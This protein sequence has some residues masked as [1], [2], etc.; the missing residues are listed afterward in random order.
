M[1]KL[2]EHLFIADNGDLFDTRKADWHKHPLREKY[3]YH[4]SDIDSLSKVKACLRAGKYAWPGGYPL[5]FITQDG[6][7][8][9]FDAVEDNF[10]QVAWDW[11]NDASTGWK[12]IGC[13]V[14]YEDEGLVCE[15]T[16]EKINSAYEEVVMSVKEFN[17]VKEY[18]LDHYKEFG[19]YPADVETEQGDVYTFMEYSIYL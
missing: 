13:A 7:A 19:F 4:F 1:H 16:H 3:S 14:N 10:Y 11:L 15:H 9:S 18:I 5:Y 17:Q 2:P 8:L 12:V 6:A